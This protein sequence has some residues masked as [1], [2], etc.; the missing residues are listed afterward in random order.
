MRAPTDKVRVFVAD[1]TSAPSPDA[2]IE[3]KPA[4]SFLAEPRDGL[5]SELTSLEYVPELAGCLVV[6]ATE[7]EENA[8]H[9]NTLWF[10]PDGQ[11]DQAR[12]V[13]DF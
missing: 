13:C 10:V 7:D 2:E 8:F 12:K 5:P 3:L 11:T 4:F 9:G 6:T 1:I